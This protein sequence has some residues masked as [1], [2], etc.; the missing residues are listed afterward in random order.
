L[1]LTSSIAKIFPVARVPEVSSNGSLAAIVAV[2]ALAMIIWE[3]RRAW[4]AGN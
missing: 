2:A 1:A 3:R 4:A